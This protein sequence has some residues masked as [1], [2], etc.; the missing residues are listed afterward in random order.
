M[1]R[2]VTCV[3]TSASVSPSTAPV[4]APVPVF[5]ALSTDVDAASAPATS[6]SNTAIVTSWY[7]RLPDVPAG[8]RGVPNASLKL[9]E[10]AMPSSR[11]CPSAAY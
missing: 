2:S 11:C 6:F 10:C 8:V 9:A 5:F 1:L 3:R 7:G 4:T